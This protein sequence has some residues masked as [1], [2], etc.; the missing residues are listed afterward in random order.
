MA[1]RRSKTKNQRQPHQ[2]KPAIHRKSTRGKP[3]IYDELKKNAT[4]CLTPT[5]IDGLDQLS[6]SLNISRSEFI[7]RVG[8]GLLKVLIDES[9]ALE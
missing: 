9:L 1:P 7:E 5:A 4:F 2:K 3:E 6:A 8:R